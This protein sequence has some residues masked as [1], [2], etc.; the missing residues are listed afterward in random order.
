MLRCGVCFEAMLPRSDGDRYAC[1]SNVQLGGAGTCPMPHRKR[2]EIDRAGLGFFERAFLDLDATREMMEVDLAARLDEIEAEL[3]R[4]TR[5]AAEKSAH[6]ARVEN[7][8]LAGELTGETYERLTQRLTGELAAAEAERDRLSAHADELRDS[9]RALDSEGDALQR[10]AELRASVLDRKR[11]AEQT[12]DVEALR[13]AMHQAFSALYLSL[14]GVIAGCEQRD[15]T[16]PPSRSSAV[17]RALESFVKP[18]AF[19]RRTTQHGTFVWKYMTQKTFR[20]E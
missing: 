13:A 10:L 19:P 17:P 15:S 2:E 11:S 1:R 18:I 6:T 4:A 14:D 9:G 5:E 20:P 3:H 16:S 12:T 7:D 8:Y